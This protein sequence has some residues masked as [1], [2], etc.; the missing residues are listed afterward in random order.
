MY[1]DFPA[2]GT[3]YTPYIP[4]KCMVL[5]NF[6]H[7]HK[8]TSVRTPCALA[9]SPHSVRTPTQCKHT[10]KHTI[11]RTPCALAPSPHSVRTPTPCTHTY[12]HTSVRTP[13]ALAASPHSVRTSTQCTH[14]YTVYAHLQA[15]KRMH[16]LRTGSVPTKAKMTSLLV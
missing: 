13:C 11:V 10:Y 9:P 5:A 6:T 7:V 2:K 14:T 12:K 15:H 8:H 4:I 3:V 1:G 16:T